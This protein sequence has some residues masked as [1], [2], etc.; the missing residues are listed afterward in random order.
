M[1]GRQGDKKWPNSLSDLEI[2]GCERSEGSCSTPLEWLAALLVTWGYWQ[3]GEAKGSPET[4]NLTLLQSSL[5]L[6]GKPSLF[7]VINDQ[8]PEVNT[9]FKKNMVLAER[10]SIHKHR[11]SGLNMNHE[12]A[13]VTKEE[14]HNFLACQVHSS[15]LSNCILQFYFKKLILPT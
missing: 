14:D 15:V 13:L 9:F 1:C 3:L 2:G 4:C 8:D 7:K 12:L 11:T 5:L 6:S 10:W